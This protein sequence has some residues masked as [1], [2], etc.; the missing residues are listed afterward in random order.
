M[1]TN[2]LR[3]LLSVGAAL[4]FSS[5]G[6]EKGRQVVLPESQESSLPWNRLLEGE[7]QGQFGAFQNR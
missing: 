3:L 6:A 7:A 5:C 2:V 1:Q 4:A